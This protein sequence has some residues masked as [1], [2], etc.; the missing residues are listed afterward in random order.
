MLGRRIEVE[1]IA[2]ETGEVKTF[3]DLPLFLGEFAFYYSSGR[4]EGEV[5]ET[6]QRYAD[7]LVKEDDN[8]A[9]FIIHRG[10]IQIKLTNIRMTNGVDWNW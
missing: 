3:Y 1:A 4:M 9:S 10:G 5:I 6:L 7:F 8:K 2:E